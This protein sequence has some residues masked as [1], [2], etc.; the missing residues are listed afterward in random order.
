MLKLKLPKFNIYFFE[1]IPILIIGLIPLLWFKEGYLAAGHDMSYPLAPT[2][3]WLDRLFVWTDR[4][5]SFSS[6]QTDAIPGIFIHG[7]QA[8]F[9]TLTGLLQLAQKLDFI[10]WLTLPGITM[11]I[12]LKDLHPN[13]DDFIL[14]I[15]GSLFYMLNHYLLQ[16]WI[17][18]EMSKFSIVAALPIVILVII[19]VV[20]KK[21][22]IIKNSIILGLTL[23]FLNG[24][25]GIP[26]WG[27]LFVA[28]L[29]CLIIIFILSGY[30]IRQ[31]LKRTLAFITLSIIFILLL[32]IYWIYPYIESFAQNYTQRVDLSGGGEGAVTWSGEISKNA[33]LTN[34]I[35]MQ[36]IPDWYD[37]PEHPYADNFLTNPLF[38]LLS[39]I[40]PI[41]G[42]IGLVNKKEPKDNTVYKIY[43]LLLLIVAIP[44]T[45]GSHPPF[46][47]IYDF[48]LRRLPGFSIFRTPFYKFGMILWFA[49]AYLIA[50]GLKNI[51]EFIYPRILSR[52]S[53]KSTTLIILSIYIVLL[54]IYNYPYFTGSF[55]NWSKK[56]STMVK[57]PD[58]IFE[59]K[60]ELDSNKF[61]TRTLL[62]PNLNPGT[63]YELYD[64]K[65]FSLSTI[66]SILSRRSVI[67]NDATLRGNEDVL[68]DSIYTQL[69]K[70]GRSNLL[71]YS[72]ADTAIIRND[73][74][75]KDTLAYNFSKLK[76]KI[77]SN[78]Q[79]LLNKQIGQWS[80]ISLNNPDN[81]PLFYTPKSVTYLLTDPLH[82]K[83]MIDIPDPQPFGDALLFSN[84][85]K[86]TNISPNVIR[87]F[88]SQYVIEGVCV[89]CSINEDR[90]D[91][92]PPRI[93]P[94]NRL[95]FLVQFIE[96]RR[97]N[98][99]K[100][101]SEK[102]DFILGTMAKNSAALEILIKD[103]KN[104]NVVESIIGDWEKKLTELEK[105]YLSISDANLKQENS[106]KIYRYLWYL[107]I[108]SQDWRSLSDSS[109]I[110]NRLIEFENRTRQFLFD[111]K[112][113]PAPSKK[114]DVVKQY[115]IGI[116]K[117]GD[118]QIN[119]YSPAGI[120]IETPKATKSVSLDNKLTDLVKVKT[121]ENWYQSKSLHLLN[122]EYTLSFESPNIQTVNIPK[123]V[124]EAK[125]AII[126][127]KD[128]DLGTVNSGVNYQVKF[129]YEDT[130]SRHLR[131]DL[132]E[133]NNEFANGKKIEIGK[134]I[135]RLPD[136]LIAYK[137]EFIY[138]PSRFAQSTYLKF[139][140]DGSY[141]S[142][143]ISQVRGIEINKMYD[144]PIAFV[145][146]VDQPQIKETPDIEFVALNQ[147]K[148]LVKIKNQPSKFILNFNSRLDNQ[149]KLR[150]VDMKK[151]ENY[152]TG[153]KK[154]YLNGK[155]IEYE[156]K[157]NHILTDWVFPRISNEINPDISLNTF[158]NGWIFDQAIANDQKVYLVEYGYQNTLYKTI[159]ISVLTFTCIVIIYFLVRRYEK[160][161]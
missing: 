155:V 120:N 130:A 117:D 6:N 1:V 115:K 89:T 17:I 129:E 58:Y 100:K 161:N 73:F 104:K 76:T 2:D 34:L 15:S 52:L 134:S 123:F 93:L 29:T 55:F 16:G 65:Y 50:I 97:F 141:F 23:F 40:F 133:K 44:F 37:N 21:K 142:T 128:I 47:F 127:C 109:E 12:L 49:Y 78:N 152:F 103:S 53:L 148:Y 71:S 125:E 118:Y 30:S 64:W 38:I 122:K 14:R 149:W 57:V 7:L 135:D 86:P 156:R 8:F 32:N 83:Y 59:A 137:V 48:L 110:A 144:P 151:A 67:I 140:L 35:K 56:Y 72:G 145:S 112:L 143:S 63:K 31:R 95:Y 159:I 9:Y 82:F 61:S 36:G 60:K 146:S 107:I 80:F 90:I 91:I 5:G 4:I 20:Y 98:N 22:S 106:H 11:Y 3:F 92:K 19:N 136:K 138:K 160:N 84:I 157:D 150:E 132:F 116:P 10:F 102:I 25:A 66:P 24:G 42:I 87:D 154:E 88:T 114:I 45:A 33:S 43:F 139:C 75:E 28:S 96:N 81:K 68:V 119:I 54:G 26:L 39:L 121:D 94:G 70:S 105:Y 124:V 147:T 153:N 41:L 79:F 74:N 51:V 18:A 13:K 69:L 77:E 101:P 99:I 113:E 126:Q 131:F 27:G 46:G 108:G 158:S 85:F 62:I 111:L